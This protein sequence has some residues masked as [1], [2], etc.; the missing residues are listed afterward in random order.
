MLTG[1][2]QQ[3][4]GHADFRVQVSLRR[5]YPVLFRQN[6]GQKVFGRRLPVTARHCYDRTAEVLAVP[7]GESFQG[8]E[9]IVYGDGGYALGQF[10][11]TE[12]RAVDQNGRC[13]LADGFTD[14][15]VGIEALSDDGNEKF[16]WL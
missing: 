7:G 13:P 3:R 10:D 9:R 6:G 5:Q 15:P 16:A 11:R 8:A 4:H 12:V 1:A 2:A 14:K